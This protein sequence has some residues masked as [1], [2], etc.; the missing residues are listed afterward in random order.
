[1]GDDQPQLRAAPKLILER[2][3][4]A[5]SLH[6]LRAAVLAHALS[7]GLAHERA[8]DLVIAVHELATNVLRHGAGQGEVRMW[9]YNRALRCQ[10]S[11]AGPQRRT[12][13]AT[14]LAPAGGRPDGPA[15]W[16]IEP[17][18]GLWLVRRL[19]DEFAAES[20]PRGTSVT[21]IFALAAGR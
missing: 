4:A 15:P 5:D 1:M 16:P 17:T 7:A 3:F 20:G 21:V 8:D 18:H 12:G 11:D 13:T 2:A 9:N 10:V 6:L 14:G 19:A